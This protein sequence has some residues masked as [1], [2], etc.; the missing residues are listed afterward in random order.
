MKMNIRIFFERGGWAARIGAFVVIAWLTS[1]TEFALAAPQVSGKAQAAPAP[2]SPS[3]K[4]SS[5]S[6]PS[7]S[8]QKVFSSPKEAAEAL[9]AAAD[10]FDVAALKAILGPDG[11]K[12][13]VTKDAVLDK[14]QAESFAAK[15]REKNAIVLDEKNPNRATLTVGEL[16][17]P[18]PIPIVKRNGKWL[19]DS[20]AGAREVLYRRIGRNELDA[21]E[22]CHDYVVAQ[23][24]YALEK[25]DGSEVNQYAQKV[26]STPGK[27]DGLAWKNPDG[28]DGGPL[29]ETVARAIAEGYTKK[30][31]K[32]EPFHGYVFKILKGQGPAAPLGK[33][34]FVIEGAMIGGFALVAA[35]VDYRVTGVKTFIVSYDGV[36][37]EKDLGPTTLAQFRAMEL[38]NPDKTW[39]P[40]RSRG[41]FRRAR[42]PSCSDVP[43]LWYAR[44]VLS[45]TPSERLA[46]EQDRP[47]FLWDC[48]LTLKQFRKGLTDT[49]PEVRA[50]L[51][52]KLMRQAKP[53][54]VFLF[55]RPREI[56]DLWPRLTRYLGRTRE[57]WSW[58][59]ETWEGQGRVWR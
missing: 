33:M 31:A 2:S 29:G 58:L 10:S 48:G 23:H 22:I 54:D 4:S 9:I 52:G 19:F 35:P 53:D 18:V 26:I 20:K 42:R 57:F 40:A 7:S 36:V 11:A 38:Y 3:K 21:I 14:L 41:E 56:R 39:K 13:V 59:F 8:S 28:T 25:H 47:Y 1:S 43:P 49:D 34:D 17:W 30:T 51:I 16:D 32:P 27:H 37:H 24:A 44:S 5:S 15:A 55:V 6:S 12:L 46:D 50:Y 45:Y